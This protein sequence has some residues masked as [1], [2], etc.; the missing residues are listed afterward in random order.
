MRITKLGSDTYL[1]TN[2]CVNR[3]VGKT[4]Y[5]LS[6]LV[7][8]SESRL[9]I[10]GVLALTYQPH[11]SKQGKIQ[12]IAWNGYGNVAFIKDLELAPVV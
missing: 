10:D 3:P 4:W 12:G 5:H 9:Y 11:Y 6:L 8:D 1:A 7:T 2:D